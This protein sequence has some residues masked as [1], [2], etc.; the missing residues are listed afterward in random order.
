MPKVTR[1]VRG[2]LA[3]TRQ[4]SGLPS[5]CS[6]PGPK[7]TKLAV[8]QRFRIGPTWALKSPEGVREGG[9]DC[10]FPQAPGGGGEQ[11]CGSR[12]LESR[13]E[14]Q[15]LPCG[16]A[17]TASQEQCL[18]S[19]ACQPRGCACSGSWSRVGTQCTLLP[20]KFYRERPPRAVPGTLGCPGSIPHIWDVF[21][22]GSRV[23]L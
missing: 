9:R 6:S 18:L 16:Q 11:G 7:I 2:D 1:L 20:G 21:V 12:H 5:Q 13:C 10:L 17:G 4:V 15:A 8:L 23:T 22:F 19:V 3:G 14:G